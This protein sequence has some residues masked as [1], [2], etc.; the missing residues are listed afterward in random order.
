VR[1]FRENIAPSGGNNDAIHTS[2]VDLL[3]L[4]HEC[5][6]FEDPAEDF[7]LDVMDF[8]F[9]DILDTMI[10]RNTVP[11]APYIML[12]IKHSLLEFDW[13]LISVMIARLIPPRGPISRGRSLSLPQLIPTPLWLMQG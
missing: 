10:H 9:H 13:S 3:Y 2:L 8:I 6:I 7:T 4:A 1:I 12:L 11:Y 5:A